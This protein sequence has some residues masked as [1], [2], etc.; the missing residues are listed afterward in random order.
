[1]GYS[2]YAIV[3]CH[4]DLGQTVGDVPVSGTVNNIPI[5]NSIV[6]SGVSSPITVP[7]NTEISLALITGSGEIDRISLI[8][9]L[10]SLEFRFY[11]DGVLLNEFALN[12][13]AYFEP[14]TLNTLGYTMIT[15]Q[16]QYG[17]YIVSLTTYYIINMQIRFQFKNS[18]EVRAFQTSGSSTTA[19]A[20]IISDTI[21]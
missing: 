5:P 7:N 21:S 15:P 19:A 14:I 16:I 12:P 6:S 17:S 8:T 3:Y 11:I 9:I 13:F 2:I 1:M 10:S 4:G 20:A 18:F